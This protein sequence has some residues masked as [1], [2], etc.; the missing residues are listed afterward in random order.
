M[1]FVDL[2]EG[3]RLRE[4][5]H[6]LRS[7]PR[8]G[9]GRWNATQH[10]RPK[11]VSFQRCACLVENN[12][13]APCC[14]RC[15]AARRSGPWTV[16]C[17]WRGW[18]PGRIRVQDRRIGG[19]LAQVRGR[20]SEFVYLMRVP[21]AIPQTGCASRA[22]AGALDLGV[23]LGSAQ[24]CGT[25]ETFPLRPCLRRHVAARIGRNRDLTNICGLRSLC[26]ASANRSVPL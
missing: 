8:P 7:R 25:T 17:R 14:Y 4:G 13:G 20:G 10:R 26:R 3:L 11:S 9:T 12:E 16:R 5:S 2:W 18:G 1:S 22:G 23:A 24:Q 15:G 6:R 19:L 21:A